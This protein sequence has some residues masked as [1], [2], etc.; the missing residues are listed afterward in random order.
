M[1]RKPLAFVSSSASSL[2][3]TSAT[4]T[5]T[6]TK[7]VTSV[8]RKETEFVVDNEPLRK[9]QRV[10]PPLPSVKQPIPPAKPVVKPTQPQVKPVA[11]EEKKKTPRETLESLPL[12]D[13]LKFVVDN[14]SKFS[15]EQVRL[16]SDSMIVAVPVPEEI[17]A[18][19]EKAQQK[20][21]RDKRT[22]NHVDVA[23]KQLIDNGYYKA[24]D[25]I[26]IRFK[27]GVSNATVTKVA[28]VF[29]YFKLDGHQHEFHEGYRASASFMTKIVGK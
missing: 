29:V 11:K 10:E 9:K 7:T 14:V 21:N 17:K 22:R 18:K 8:K 25:R 28:N 19:I 20:K 3:S 12:T 24:G 2:S 23:S 1:M 16:L 15:T 26:S 27:N 6:T 5:S 13:I 4:S